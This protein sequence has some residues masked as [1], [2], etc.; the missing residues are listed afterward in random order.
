MNVTARLVELREAAGL[1]QEEIAFR[2]GCGQSV[3]SRIE[4]RGDEH[5]SIRHLVSYAKALGVQF[6]F[7]ITEPVPTDRAGM[8]FD[9]N[10]RG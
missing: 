4:C 10:E 8:S 1:S 5:L 2:M 9:T 3:V 6:T 7:E